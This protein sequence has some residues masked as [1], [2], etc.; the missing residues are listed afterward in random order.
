MQHHDCLLLDLDGTVFRGSLPTEGAVD[1][2]ARADL[3]TLYVTNNA[4][5]SAAD[6]ATHLH[7][8]GFAAAATDVAT[9]AQA[10][11]HLLAQLL[12]PGSAVLVVGTQALA[13]EVSSAGLRPVRLS[14][15]QPVAVVQGHSR[16]TGW[17]DLTEAAL[18]LQSGALWVATNTDRTLPT[19][20]GLVP[21]NGSM[22]AALCAA[23]DRTPRIAGKPSP[24]LLENALRRGRF[25]APLVVGDRLDT[26]IAGANAAS[27][28][29]LLVLSGVA[30]AADVVAAP[31][32]LRPTHLGHDL[33]TLHADNTSSTI[34]AHPAW[35]VS[36]EDAGGGARVTVESTGSRVAADD[37][38]VVRAT[39]AA[40]WDAGLTGGFSV[41]AGD[42]TAGAALQPWGLLQLS[43]SAEVVP[44]AHVR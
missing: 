20:R 28:P 37:L 10:A 32:A 29:S 30:T 17:S 11:A 27:L 31:P 7:E 13:A 41:H 35:R 9:S 40:V 19:E 34:S 38:A 23:T 18:A 24:C 26:D 43:R 22:V 33:R 21:G 15:E 6:V 2:L 42:D 3:R 1:S 12:P 14:S 16:Q 5:R 8:L 36:V 39:A 25:R 44:P 4:S